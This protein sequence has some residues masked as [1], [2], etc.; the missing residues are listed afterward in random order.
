MKP[1]SHDLGKAGN[2]VV[3]VDTNGTRYTM[4]YYEIHFTVTTAT[5][6]L[7]GSVK[8]RCLIKE[9]HIKPAAYMFEVFSAIN[10]E[11]KQITCLEKH[12][13]FLLDVHTETR[14]VRHLYF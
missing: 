7:Y 13:E 2:K 8:Q 14:N 1:F 9:L 4:N 6:P 12:L 11:W 10:N 3:Y 5:F